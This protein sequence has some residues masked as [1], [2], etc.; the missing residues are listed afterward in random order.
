M[1][2]MR[3]LAGTGRA[4]RRI[5]GVG[6]LGRR[7]ALIFVAVALA[8][9]AINVIISAETIGAD[10]NRIAVR[11]EAV[12]AQSIS[13]TAAAAYQGGTWANA[14]L[15]HAF[16][17]AQRGDAAV[18]VTDAADHF[19]GES[20]RFTR[21]P[22]AHRRVVP[23]RVGNTIVGEATVRFSTASQIGRAHV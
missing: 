22:T 3:W 10:V 1:T 16:E 12:L 19:V 8:A 21:L 15:H 23:I 6:Q 20:R 11:Q 5:F 14:D 2:G 18:L 9:I 13:V 7:L 17:R 4:N